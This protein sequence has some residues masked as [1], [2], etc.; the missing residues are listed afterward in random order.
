MH[1][2][3]LKSIV[4]VASLVDKCA[5]LNP[6]HPLVQ[7]H[8]DESFARGFKCGSCPVG[9]T[10][11][12]ERCV[13]MCPFNCPYGMKCIAP[14]TCRCRKGYYGV[15]CKTPFCSKG[16]FNEGKCIRPDV[17]S[18]PKGFSGPSCLNYVCTPRCQNGGRC[19]ANNK[20]YC[21]HGFEGLY[22]ERMKC[23][24]KCLNGGTCIG[25]YFCS[26]ESTFAGLRCET[27]VGELVN[28]NA[29]GIEQL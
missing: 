20:C 13:S 4:C 3:W 22:C 27:H 5:A 24:V 12:G 25:P 14:Y 16:C 7:C 8:I 19:L 10:G 29:K 11:N 26:C 9:F 18:C 23:L 17:C 1:D 6:C 28:T 2:T 21:Q 15:G